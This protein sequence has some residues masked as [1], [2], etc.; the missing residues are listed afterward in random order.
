MPI[1]THCLQTEADDH[2][3]MFVFMFVFFKMM[4]LS[5]F[6]NILMRLCEKGQHRCVRGGCYFQTFIDWN[7]K[8]SF[9]YAYISNVYLY[10]A[11]HVLISQCLWHVFNVLFM[12]CW[13]VYLNYFSVCCCASLYQMCCCS[14]SKVVSMS[15][16][17][18]INWK[19]QH[20]LFVS[21][22]IRAEHHKHTHTHTQIHNHKETW[23]NRK[24]NLERFIGR[25][26]LMEMSLF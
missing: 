11:V 24:G 23:N 26:K 4:Y 12:Q 5:D 8:R 14:F 13:I 17:R 22:D 2:Q 1:S 21:V 25:W 18:L 19:K 20:V 10:D 6:V 16:L 3:C 9:W 7:W 15:S